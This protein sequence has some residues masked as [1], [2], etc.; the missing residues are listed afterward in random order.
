MAIITIS[1]GSFSKGK[2][3]AEKVAGV[4]GYECI[5]RE[6][7]LEA[8]EHFNIP[9]IKLERALHDA[10]SILQRFTYGKERYMAYIAAALLERVHEDNVVYHGLA[11]QF[12][13]RD[14]S[15]V[16]KVRI[17]A[18]MESR[19]NLEIAREHLSRSEAIARLQKDDRERRQWSLKLY[20]V[21]TWN[22]DL[23]DMVL[24]V[25]KLNV[26]NI[27]NIICDT[28]RLK[29]FQATPQSQKVLDNL[30]LAASVRARLVQDYPMVRT[31]ASDDVVIVDAR[32][33][34]T[35]EP[36]LADR[37]REM[38]LQVPGVKKVRMHTLPVTAYVSTNSCED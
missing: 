20:G 28:A 29:Q 15:H 11:G 37:I 21:D 5:S 6:V 4:L 18:E 34:L 1:R 38:A 10:P 3:V 30:L 2:E 13:M 8:S 31:E 19:V 17:L 36:E 26:D 12:L 16:L 35:E 32:F 7:L 23:Y 24:H 9:E 33:N 25:H 14:V 27:V 22:P